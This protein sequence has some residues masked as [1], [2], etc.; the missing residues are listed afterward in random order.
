[1]KMNLITAILMTMATLAWMA[2]AVLV[3]QSG[4]GAVSRWLVVV[5]FVVMAAF[6]WTL[7]FRKKN[8]Q[9]SGTE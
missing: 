5:A 8:A 1:M 3:P 4:E 9:R 6:Y 7:Y 2:S